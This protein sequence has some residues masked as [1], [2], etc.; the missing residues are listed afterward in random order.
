MAY[1]RAVPS[2]RAAADD[3]LRRYRAKRDFSITAEPR[4]T[5]PPAANG[6]RFVVQRHRASRL[7][8]DVRLEAD[9]V[10]VSWAV[11]KGPTLDPAAKRLAVH[12]EDHPLDYYDFEGVIAAG[13]YGGGD[14]IVWDWG[15]WALTEGDDPV[16]AIEAGD[17]HLALDGDKLRGRFALVR[18]G[19]DGREQWLLI[20]KRDDDAAGGWDPEDHPRSVKSG[21]TNDEVRDAPAASWTGRASWAG[22]T[23]AELAS[24]DALGAA[25]T[26]SIGG[27]DVRLAGLDDQ[28]LHGR[29]K[30]RALTR[31][32]LVR[33][34]ATMAPA[35]LG[36]LAGRP[37][38]LAER[39][40]PPDWMRRAGHGSRQHVVAD[41]AAALAWLAGHGV[42]ELRPS[43]TTVDDPEHPGWAVFVLG[44]QGD[45]RRA[46]VLA[47]ARLHRTALEHLGVDGRPALAGGTTIQLLV[48]VGSGST[49][50]EVRRFVETVT[51]VIVASAP[52]A[53]AR[54]ATG[55][56]PESFVAPFSALARPG[57]PVVVPVGWDDLSSRRAQWTVADAARRLGEHGDPLAPLVDGAPRIPSLDDGSASARRGTEAR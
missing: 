50:A 4:G 23:T 8:Y 21:R 13:E 51:A 55:G 37:L 46:D 11:P 25:G 48:P 19:H 32:D 43:I 5:D 44:A 22:A 6:W 39:V 45:A 3:R 56:F 38:D 17:L 42:V 10:L 16:A 26:W 12:V 14:V 40:R 53:V 52:D 30:G 20:K 24:L 36:Y 47:L 41:S 54:A 7:H 35:L 1:R 27:H 29:G 2:R 28:V 33:Y 34:H 9:G 31:R 15:T 18:R 49:T 57:A